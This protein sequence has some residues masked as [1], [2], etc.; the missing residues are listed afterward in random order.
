[1]SGP[2]WPDDDLPPP[3]AHAAEHP[4]A[5]WSLTAA[6]NVGLMFL[7]TAAAVTFAAAAG[8]AA[9]D[10]TGKEL[11]LG[12]LGLVEFLPRA[13]LVFVTGAVADR[14]N[15]ALIVAVS[16][17]V[18]AVVCLLVVVYV[19]QVD[20]I[21]VSV[22]LVAALVFGVAQAFRSPAAR[23]LMS[24]SLDPAALPWL[25]VRWVFGWQ[26]AAI[27][28]PVLM[29]Y[30]YTRDPAWAFVL[31]A[32]TA[33]VGVP[34]A[35]LLLHAPGALEHEHHAG[36][37]L[38]DALAGVRAVRQ[39]P[40][41]L[42]AISLDLFAVLFGGALA[43]LPA[44]AE[45]R[46]HVG[47]TGFGWL[48]AAPGIGSL[49]MTLW[50]ARRPI[51]RRVGPALL[52][53]VGVFGVGH[54]VLGMTHSFVVAFVAI[55]IAAAADG[56]SVFVRHTLVPLVTP[57]NLRGRVNA[58]E[59]VFIGASN[60]LGAF[61]SGV[62]AQMLGTGPAVTLGGVLTL[63]VV[64]GWWKAFPTLVRLDGFPTQVGVSTAVED[65]T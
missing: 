41:L 7:S 48:R 9:Y 10:V 32:V 2:D 45:E 33:G 14:V 30:L 5:R 28:A 19:A 26:F 46:L 56:V 57:P 63:V 18:E 39:T 60:E 59:S 36:P 54:V 50:L 64:G 52:L 37:G 15:R 35:L 21:N 44:I 12:L 34:V 25:V 11:Y 23:A 20:R 31:A 13:L 61:E 43:L 16:T 55:L 1:M 8:K 4:D 42:A 49:V 3:E 38:R 24:G 47:T 51:R 17:G 62:T 29:G 58:V 65:A 27:A 6:A 22:L 40:V 53:S